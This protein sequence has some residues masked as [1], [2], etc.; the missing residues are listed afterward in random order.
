M[1]ACQ[2]CIWVIIAIIFSDLSQP[3][4]VEV[5]DNTK[6]NNHGGEKK[7]MKQIGGNDYFFNR[8]PSWMEH[9]KT[10]IRNIVPMPSG[11]TLS[12]QDEETN[13]SKG[14]KLLW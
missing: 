14:N 5:D 11:R 2:K 1:F 10:K 3:F 12:A 6:V 8:I 4:L 9:L 7:V 13:Q